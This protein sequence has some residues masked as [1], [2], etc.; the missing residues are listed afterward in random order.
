MNEKLLYY[1]WQHQIAEMEHLV[2]S[3]GK[4]VEVLWSGE[5]NQHQGPDFLHAK[6]RYEKTIWI[7]QVEIHVRSSDWFRHRHQND[8]HYN[9]VILHVV[10][11]HDH[12]QG[13]SFP[14]LEL[15]QFVSAHF[16]QLYQSLMRQQ[17]FIP[18]EI[19]RPALRDI[20][21]KKW[22]ERLL[23]E[24]LTNKAAVMLDELKTTV[25]HWD[26]VCWRFI[27]KGFG[28]KVN[29]E[30]FY[31]MSRT[32]PWRLLS[33]YRSDRTVIES[34]LMGQMGLLTTDR[35]DEYVKTLQNNYHH[36][37]RMHRLEPVANSLH[38]LRMRPIG[39]PTI[40]LSQLAA[41]IHA[42]EFLLSDFLQLLPTTTLPSV[43]ELQAST[44]WNRH[45]VFDTEP[46]KFQIKNTG[47]N[48]NEHMY[49]NVVVPVLFAFGW[50]HHDESIKSKSLQ[51]L[52]QLP[53]ENNQI[54]RGFK[55]L[56]YD[57]GS[58]F[59]SQALLQLKTNYCDR[60]RCLECAIGN[61]L[62][63]TNSQLVSTGNQAQMKFTS[64]IK[65]G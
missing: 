30:A 17:G 60:Q 64:V 42:H 59:D 10:W 3:E 20:V 51:L 23:A 65:S 39:F 6:I 28:G 15:K 26:E 56:G 24:R 45:Y 48:F 13:F 29:G 27:C 37:K 57:C 12:I 54:I 18:C 43:F 5:P 62:L 44:Y 34:L 40:R 63:K 32:L 21:L 33:R 41:F 11:E 4:T 55:R 50:H 2:C 19:H 46:G 52:E 58:A 47:K 36:L 38:F 35:D 8:P 61:E 16:L 31:Q 1:I 9:N 25:N 53:A 49:I 14:I 22:Q 7:G